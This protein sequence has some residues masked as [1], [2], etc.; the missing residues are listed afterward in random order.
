MQQGGNRV[1][2]VGEERPDLGPTLRY[3]IRYAV[4]DAALSLPQQSHY[5]RPLAEPTW[6]LIKEATEILPAGRRRM[7]VQELHPDQV[8]QALQSEPVFRVRLVPIT[9]H[10]NSRRS[11]EREH[12]SSPVYRGIEALERAAA[13][14]KEATE[15]A[16]VAAT[17]AAA[18]AASAYQATRSATASAGIAAGAAAAAKVQV[19]NTPLYNMEWGSQT[20]LPTCQAIC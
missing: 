2:F 10:S 9:R 18:I 13:K 1:T 20:N 6:A 16:A 19:T 11:E 3:V 15:Q 12:T 7:W 14:A 4:R 17:H 5:E 8:Q